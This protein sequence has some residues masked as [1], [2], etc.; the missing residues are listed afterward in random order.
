MNP[1]RIE[2]LLRKTPSPKVPA[3]LLQ[4][5]T[6]GIRLPRPAASELNN[7]QRPSSWMRRWLP[8]LSFAGL[9]LACVVVLAVQ[10]NTLNTLQQKN[11]E[12]RAVKEKQPKTISDNA[13]Q[14]VA[15]P[16]AAG[17]LER[18]RKD[19]AELVK[20]QAEIAQLNTQLKGRDQLQAENQR[21]KA[22]AAA[23]QD[24][25][26]KAAVE[27]KARAERI[28]CI[29][30]LKQVGLAARIWAGD[31]NDVYPTNFIC[32]TNELS[33]WKIL[34]C[35]SDKSRKVTNWTD[36]AEGNISYVM[37]VFGIKEGGPDYS[38]NLVFVECPIHH[39]VC[40]MDGSVQQLNQN[41][42]SVGPVQPDGSQQ[43]FSQIKMVN[44]RKMLVKQ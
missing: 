9:F 35:P 41:D 40:L 8:A 17:E 18:L 24:P 37:D 31:N 34:H 4:K 39:N 43:I 5:L 7:W 23:S 29:N 3:D 25:Y 33:T 10:T 12:M 36:V 13:A 2:E 42:C 32:M 16:A 30:N 6:V 44:G 21:L 19:N 26:E 14:A 22:Q 1:E 20:L 27:A 38:P 28:N 15:E 11:T